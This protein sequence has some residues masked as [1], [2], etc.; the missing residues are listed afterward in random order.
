MNWTTGTVRACTRASLSIAIAVIA[1][2]PAKA[3]DIPATSAAHRSTTASAEWVTT[4]NR[5]HPTLAELLEEA[6]HKSP[7]LHAARNEREAAAQRIAPAGAL[8]DPMLE[9]GIVS[10]PIDSFSVKREDMTMKMLGLSQR[11]PFPGKRDLRRSVAAMDAEALAHA[12]QET[13]N[14][15]VRDVRLAYYDLALAREAMRLVENNRSV[16]TQ[17]LRLAEGRYT[18]GQGTQADVLRAQAQMSRIGEEQI[19]LDRERLVAEAELDRAVGRNAG[20]SAPKPGPLTLDEATLSPGDLETEALANRP[21]LRALRSLLS[22]SERGL[23]LSQRDR[24]PDFDVRLAYGQRDRMPDGIR[25]SDLVSL[26]VAINLPVWRQ[27]R[28]EPRVAEAQAM[29]DQAA[30]LYETQR[31]ET[32][33]RLR[34]QL[35]LAEQSLRTARLYRNEL[36]PQSRLTFDSALASY[37][38]NRGAFMPLLESRMAT[39]EYETRYLSALADYNKA[40]AEI[41]LLTGRNPGMQTSRP[42]IETRP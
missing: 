11:F 34:Q 22:R 14:R 18:V 38:V 5:V 13:L 26:T 25:R 3:V 16:L 15:V 12:Y 1:A 7:E 35:A 9:A 17:L 37:Q 24:Y 23:A 28:I 2:A 30:S 20:G 6:L 27:A 32:V 4:A 41:E 36:V 19:R 40:L 21:Q 33:M 42:T 31:R 10:L 29:R 8:D 39:F